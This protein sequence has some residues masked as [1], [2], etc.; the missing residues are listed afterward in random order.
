MPDSNKHFLISRNT[1]IQCSSGCANFST[2]KLRMTPGRLLQITPNPHHWSPLFFSAGPQHL[3][4][5]L[6]AKCFILM[7]ARW[8]RGDSSIGAGAPERRPSPPWKWDGAC[9]GGCTAGPV[10]RA[11]ADQ[12]PNEDSSCPRG[13]CYGPEAGLTHHHMAFETDCTASCDPDGARKQA[14]LSWLQSGTSQGR[15]MRF[16]CNAARTLFF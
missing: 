11:G 7:S 4:P 1:F 14:V 9:G 15:G 6:Y 2:Y 13:W 8:F 10:G 12:L 3:F 5:T 16:M